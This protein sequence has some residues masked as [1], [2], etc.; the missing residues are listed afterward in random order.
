MRFLDSYSLQARWKRLFLAWAVVFAP[1]L[2]WG[3]IAE[4]VWERQ[5]FR[6]DDPTLLW[7]HAHSNAWLDRLMLGLTRA[8]VYPLLIASALLFVAL[9]LL[10]RRHEATF[11]ALCMGGASALNLVAKMIFHRTRPD[12]W[13]SL[14]PKHDYSFPSG[15]AMVSSAFVAML[16]VMLWRATNSDSKAKLWRAVAAVVGVGFVLA[17]GLSRLYL[18][19][20]FPSDILA[21][22]L[23]SLSWI[24]L[25][26]A[27]TSRPNAG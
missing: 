15:H 26:R 21:G 16:L 13:L 12:L 19:V 17:V 6:F 10:S 27:I 3:A 23:A 8:G 9:W 1:L 7:L 18:G 25:I 22:W 2:A 11:V 20:H 14:A 4:D 24:A 5:S